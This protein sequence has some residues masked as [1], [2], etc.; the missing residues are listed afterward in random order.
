MP[1]HDESLWVLKRMRFFPQR[2]AGTRHYPPQSYYYALLLELK[3]RS[4][5]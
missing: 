2:V 4:W 3:Y 1:T 5:R